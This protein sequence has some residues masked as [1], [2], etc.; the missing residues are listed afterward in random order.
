[1]IK[2]SKFN[3]EIWDEW[4]TITNKYLRAFCEKHEYD[5][6]EATN[7]WVANFDGTICH[8][9][10]EYI[11]MEDIIL[12]I[13]MK[14]PVEEFQKWYFYCIDAYDAGANVP[15][16]SSWLLGCPRL[17]KEEMYDK[18]KRKEEME[19]LKDKPMN[20]RLVYLKNEFNKFID[21]YIKNGEK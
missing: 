17:T 1:M 8:C 16:Y 15:N 7:S 11:S 20:E 19:N 5:F 6:D 4:V 13:E 14:A 21:E 3:S 12:D 2:T 10:D 9:G 18:Q